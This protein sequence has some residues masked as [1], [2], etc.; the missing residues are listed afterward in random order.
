[1]A[2]SNIDGNAALLIYRHKTDVVSVLQTAK[3]SAGGSQTLSFQIP[4][5]M[6]AAD[7]NSNGYIL[8]DVITEETLPAGTTMA[9]GN[10]RSWVGERH[11]LARATRAI[12]ICDPP[13]GF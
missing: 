10:Y 12:K 7:R 9:S 2:N 11:L 4:W 6:I 13:T 1:M 3:V 8:V 5:S